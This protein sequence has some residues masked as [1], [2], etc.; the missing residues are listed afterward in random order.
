VFSR[1]HPPPVCGFDY[2]QLSVIPRLSDVRPDK[3]T[4]STR[5]TRHL[6]RSFPF[7][8]SPMDAV[9]GEDLAIKVLDRGGLPILHGF[10][11][12]PSELFAIVDAI[13]SRYPDKE[14]RL[15]L[16]I[17]PDIDSLKDII[18]LFDDRISVV[19]LDTLHRSPHLHLNAIQELK[20]RF[21][22]L[23]VISGNIVFGEDCGMLAEA[24]VDAIRVGMTAAS[25]NRGRELVGCG[26]KQASAVFECAQAASKL[27]I[28]II[29]DGGIQTISD[30]IIALALGA[31]TVMMGRMFSRLPESA[32][33]T[34]QN[35]DGRTVKLYRG[36][37]RKETISDDL[38]AEGTAKELEIDRPFDE[39]IDDWM[40]IMKLAISRSG[41]SSLEEFKTSAS[42]EF[43]L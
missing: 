3:V 28:P 43:A 15:G 8:P 26:R 7:I 31:D 9:I 40:K 11:D 19:A 27:G 2:S 32:A 37:S 22:H 39:T 38:I 23:D 4:L 16:L 13:K 1:I 30:A 34:R 14:H 35:P 5:I 36:M 20:H 18:P 42:I 41:C 25:I 12:R 29:A 6:T 21:P 33:P 10:Y 24:G 17:S